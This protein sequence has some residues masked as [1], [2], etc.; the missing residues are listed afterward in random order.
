MYL[1]VYIEPKRKYCMLKAFLTWME[2]EKLINLRMITYDNDRGFHTRFLIQ[3]GIYIAQ[4]L[5]LNMCYEYG[6]YL[7]G[8]YSTELADD[9]YAF[10]DGIVQDT[11]TIN[12]EFDA[13]EC[14]KLMNH[15][16]DWLE[17][18]TT[19]IHMSSHENRKYR[20]VNKVWGVKFPYSKNYIRNIL[21]ELLI[22]KFSGI[23]DVR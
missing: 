5:G 14:L 23:L 1:Y 6:R 16:D 21:E 10:A 7:N 3:K 4:C 22:T 19:L 2:Q 17:I 13:N 15:S 8:P 9:Y 11:D 18:A 12:Q 20:L